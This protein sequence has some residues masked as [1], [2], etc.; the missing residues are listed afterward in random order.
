MSTDRG[1]AHPEPSRDEVDALAGATVVEFGTPSCGYCRAAQPL[2]AAAFAARP[3]LR[4][5]KVEDGSGRPLGR[6]FGV[7]LWPTLVVLRDGREVARVVRPRSAAEVEQA[8]A[9]NDG[10]AAESSSGPTP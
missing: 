5:L 9:P 4:H 6:S 10:E 7:K 1:Y 8:L 2:I 3:G